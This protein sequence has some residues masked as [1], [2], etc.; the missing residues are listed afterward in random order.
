VAHNARVS[1]TSTLARLAR[2]LSREAR[3]RRTPFY[4][5]YPYRGRLPLADCDARGAVDPA[6]RVFFNR[7]PKAANSSVAMQLAELRLGHAPSQRDAKR[8]FLRPS[9]LTAQ[10]VAELTGYFKFTIVRNPYTRV[11]SAYLNKIVGGKKLAYMGRSR[12]EGA[13][14]SFADFLAYL[15]RDGLHANAHWTPQAALLLLPRERLD[16]VGRVERLNEDLQLVVT[17]LAPSSAAAVAGA[18]PPRATRAGTD[19]AHHYDARCA[20]LVRELYGEDF[21]VFGY[22]RELSEALTGR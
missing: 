16:F 6:L 9:E 14:P 8:S 3:L 20:A 18:A 1:L 12:G 10:Q 11:L 17:K 2:P 22:S 21:A 7:I 4:R 5:T 15:A 19:L 13:P